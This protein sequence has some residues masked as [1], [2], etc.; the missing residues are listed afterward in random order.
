MDIWTFK[1]MNM[2]VCQ[3]VYAFTFTMCGISELNIRMQGGELNS[4]HG[5]HT[6]QLDGSGGRR[7]FEPPVNHPP[8]GLTTDVTCGLS[9]LISLFSH[10]L[11]SLHIDG[12]LTCHFAH[13]VKKRNECGLGPL[14][15][16]VNA[17]V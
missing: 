11:P 13:G 5:F 15:A 8:H 10:S 12:L 6:D 1:Q 14:H 9:N 17:S 7:I 2:C 16:H 4:A 3:C